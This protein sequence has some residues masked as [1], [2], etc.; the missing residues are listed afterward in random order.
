MTLEEALAKLDGEPARIALEHYIA[1][2]WVRPLPE[3]EGWQF[4]ELDVARAHL[5]YYLR[6]ELMVG[7]E[8]MDVVLNLL[9]QLYGLRDRMDAL[10]RALE[11]QAPDVRANIVAKIQEKE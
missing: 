3:A 11:G 5:V 6:H 4:D 9:D 7:D 8:A 10:S 2:A 1:R